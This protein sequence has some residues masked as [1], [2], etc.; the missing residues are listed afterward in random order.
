MFKLNTIEDLYI[1]LNWNKKMEVLRTIK[2]WSQ[3]VAAEKCFTG[4]KTYWAWESGNTYPRKN[5]RRVIAQAFD[6]LEKEIFG[7][8]KFVTKDD[9]IK[10]LEQ[11]NE[12]LRSELIMVNT[13]ISAWD[14]LKNYF[15]TELT[16]INL[17]THEIYKLTKTFSQL[18]RTTFKLKQVQELSFNKYEIAKKIIESN[19]NYMKGEL[20]E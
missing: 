6:V 5:S 20:N 14:K 17:D 4:Q 16:N 8:E 13:E 2:G 1:N 7:G 18:L 11:E 19:I 12:R 10:E 9:Y 15:E 3:E